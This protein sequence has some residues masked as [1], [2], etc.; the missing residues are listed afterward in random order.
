MPKKKLKLVHK[1]IKPKKPMER[2]PVSWSRE[3]QH[4]TTFSIVDFELYADKVGCN[5]SDVRLEC[6]VED[7]A[8][9]SCSSYVEA[10]MYSSAGIPN[11]KYERELVVYNKDMAK[12]EVKLAKYKAYLKAKKA[13]D[14]DA[15]KEL[16]E[17]LKSKYGD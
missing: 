7:D 5:V 11:P 13:E 8:Y 12:Y 10:Y 14:I 1:P 17:K 6:A 9:R 2:I 16:Y 3:Q 4:D 15:E